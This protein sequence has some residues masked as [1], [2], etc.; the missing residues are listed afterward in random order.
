MAI[1]T[2]RKRPTL[3][4]EAGLFAPNPPIRPKPLLHT[5]LRSLSARFAPMTSRSASSKPPCA[6]EP[7][8]LEVGAGQTGRKQPSARGGLHAL[9]TRHTSRTAYARQVSS[10][11]CQHQRRHRQRTRAGCAAATET[12]RSQLYMRCRVQGAVR[13][14]TSR[15]QSRAI[16]H[17][18][19]SAPGH[20]CRERTTG[21]GR[22][23]GGGWLRA[24][25]LDAILYIIYIIGPKRRLSR[26]C[27]PLFAFYLP[28]TPVSQDPRRPWPAPPRLLLCH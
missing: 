5:G 23:F 28:G 10:N 13:A 26:P 19:H 7:V 21:S 4:V 8:S 1:E 9:N 15:L 20:P 12:Q 11:E 6:H 24:A 22:G 25:G 16:T 14:D 3:G 27:R 18:M 17:T 2:S